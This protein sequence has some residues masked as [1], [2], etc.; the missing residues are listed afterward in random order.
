[1]S[2]YAQNVLTLI[3][4]IGIGTGFGL[5]LIYLPA[6]VSVTTYFDKYRSLATGIAVCGSGFGTF[7]F[8]PLLNYFIT[9]Y[10]WRGA[11]F[12]LAGIVLNCAIFG[13]LFRPLK[14]TSHPV[15]DATDE[16][17]TCEFDITPHSNDFDLTRFFHI[18]F[19]AQINKTVHSIT[20]I[21]T[22]MVICISITIR[23]VAV[24]TVTRFMC[25]AWT[26]FQR[27]ESAAL[28]HNW[29]DRTAS[30]TTDCCRRTLA[31]R[32]VCWMGETD[33]TTVKHKSRTAFGARSVSRC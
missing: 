13:A 14:R 21:T 30:D 32:M 25:P 15:A 3:F 29:C 8:A 18:I 16:P 27:V 28:R 24:G 5:G 10:Q 19:F 4:T 33:W 20:A 6:I 22:A 26:S 12:I 2:V 1:M 17:D 9:G 11:L 23:G 31:N 7:L